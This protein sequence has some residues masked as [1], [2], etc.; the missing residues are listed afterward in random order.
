MEDGCERSTP[1]D[2]A[3]GMAAAE[4]PT[5]GASDTERATRPA[6]SARE[7]DTS[8]INDTAADDTGGR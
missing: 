2:A 6:Q 4:L 8:G 5:G 1:I 3:E 7:T